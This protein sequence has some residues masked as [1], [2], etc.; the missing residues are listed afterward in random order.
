MLLLYK[1]VNII[2]KRRD[3]QSSC[4]ILD[5]ALNIFSNVIQTTL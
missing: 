2:D 1:Y 5:V 4:G 3:G